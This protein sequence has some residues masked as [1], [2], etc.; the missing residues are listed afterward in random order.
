MTQMTHMK[1]YPSLLANDLFLYITDQNTSIRSELK[2]F[3]TMCEEHVCDKCLVIT[4]K[5]T[6]DQNVKVPD[7]KYSQEN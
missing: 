2:E 3:F 5:M 6:S 1:L 4:R 7:I